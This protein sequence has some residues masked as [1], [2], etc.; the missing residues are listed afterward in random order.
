MT[1]MDR[2]ILP[3]VVKPVNYH[4]S[5]FDLELGGS[6]VYKGIVKIDAQVTSSTKEIV[7]NSKEIKV[8]NAE[9]FGR[10]GS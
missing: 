8:Q 6:W 2:C 7:L 1:S 9:I 5:L 3:D 10:D 4:V